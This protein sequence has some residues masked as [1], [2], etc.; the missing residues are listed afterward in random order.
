MNMVRMQ[1]I[2]EAA[3]AAEAAGDAI[4]CDSLMAYLPD[5]FGAIDQAEFVVA[6]SGTPLAP[7][8]TPPAEAS[9]QDVADL[10]EF[11]RQATIERAELIALQ[12]GTSQ[13]I[14]TARTRLAEALALYVSGQP[15][16]S[17]HELRRDFLRSEHQKRVDAAEGRLPAHDG[18]I[19][20]RDRIGQVAMGQRGGRA[21]GNFRRP[22]KDHV[23][24][25]FQGGAARK[26]RIITL[27]DGRRTVTR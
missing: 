7:K 1:Y 9:P 27:P 6:L 3:K 11:I 20:P 15:Q 17:D 24:P 8:P 18:D 21:Q 5:D 12:K 14:R 25:F 4:N 22:P 10:R 19:V 26:A 23:G 16:M 2:I 13:N